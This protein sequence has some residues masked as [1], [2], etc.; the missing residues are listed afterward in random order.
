[1]ILL[2]IQKRSRNLTNIVYLFRFQSQPDTVADANNSSWLN[3]SLNRSGQRP[4]LTSDHTSQIEQNSPSSSPVPHPSTSRDRSYIP[5]SQESMSS[6]PDRADPTTVTKTFRA[7]RKAAA[8]ASLASRDKTPNTKSRRKRGRG[9]KNTGV[10]IFKVDILNL[11]E[12]H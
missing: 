2:N 8:Q 6:L 4:I 10:S 12:A 5:D 11:F 9:Q 1:M 3:S 7:G